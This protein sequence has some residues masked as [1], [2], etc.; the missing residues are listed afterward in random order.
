M[1][2]R[3]LQTP[4][5][6]LNLAFRLLR[7]LHR[8]RLKRLD[9]L[10]LPVHIVRC[11]FERVEL[12]LQLVHDGLIL[13]HPAVMRE[14]NALR[15]LAEHLEFAPRVIVALLERLQ[16]SRGL[17]SQT[18]RVGHFGPVEFERCASLLWV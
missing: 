15:R 1:L 18:E 3:L 17:A 14:I 6:S 12:G 7:A 2:Q 5:L 9:R 8:L 13:Q 4:Q 11:G 16:R 10:E